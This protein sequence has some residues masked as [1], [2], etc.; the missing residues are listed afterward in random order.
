VGVT[1]VGEAAENSHQAHGAEFKHESDI[2]RFGYV[3]EPANR[4]FA[5]EKKR[6]EGWGACR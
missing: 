4:S 5:H 6:P 2:R 3:L 1:P